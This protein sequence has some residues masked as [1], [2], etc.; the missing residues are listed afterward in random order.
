MGGAE[1]GQGD[2]GVCQPHAAH[3]AGDVQGYGAVGLCE[4]QTVAQESVDELGG[5]VEFHPF[6]GFTHTVQAGTLVAKYGV[7]ALLTGFPKGGF[8]L[9]GFAVGNVEHTFAFPDG[10][11]TEF[12]HILWED[13]FVTAF[14][15]EGNH[16][17]DQRLHYGGTLRKAHGLV[18]AAGEVNDFVQLTIDN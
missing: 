12:V 6:D 13:D 5:F 18:D 4:D 16:L 10:A 3:G 8:E 7:F 15:E 9:G 17:V 2:D 11:A 1:F 14:P